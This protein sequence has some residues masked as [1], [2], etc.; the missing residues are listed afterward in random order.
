MSVFS[1]SRYIHTPIYARR[2]QQYIFDIRN[3][4]E[5]N[6]ENADY[7]TVVQ[8]D[9]ID[10][11]AYKAYGNANLYWAILDSNKLMSELDLVPGMVLVIPPYEQVVSVSE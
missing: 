9:T 6:L 10:G 5:F 8:G 1:G 7:Y 3:K 2:G 11:I 4:Y